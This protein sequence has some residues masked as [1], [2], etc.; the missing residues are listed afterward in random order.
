M[1]RLQHWLSCVGCD[2]RLR[3]WPVVFTWGEIDFLLFAVGWSVILCLDWRVVKAVL[4]DRLRNPSSIRLMDGVLLCD[5]VKGCQLQQ[6][7]EDF[8][9]QIFIR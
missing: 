2:V 3:F 1:G 5:R 7:A 8:V 9:F 4:E 6:P